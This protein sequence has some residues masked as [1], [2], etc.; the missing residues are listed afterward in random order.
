MESN[1]ITNAQGN[2]DFLELIRCKICLLISLNPVICKKCESVFCKLCIDNWAKQ[3]NSCPLRCKP[4]EIQ[5]DSRIIRNILSKFTYRCDICLNNIRLSDHEEHQTQCNQDLL[6]CELCGDIMMQYFMNT[7]LKLFCPNVAQTCGTCGAS[8]KRKDVKESVQVDRLAQLENELRLK[9]S[10]I[11]NLQMKIPKQGNIMCKQLVSSDINDV[12]VSDSSINQYRIKLNFTKEKE[13][14]RLNLNDITGHKKK[15]IMVNYLTFFKLNGFNYLIIAC[16]TGDIII[17]N[18]A[19]NKVLAT[20]NLHS[21]NFTQL[22]K[23]S[24]G[25]KE[26]LITSSFDR[27]IC[28]T[29]L[30][31]LETVK[32]NLDI[33][34]TCFLVGVS[35]DLMYYGDLK[36]N[37]KLILL[38]DFQ[39]VLFKN[40]HKSRIVNIEYTDN[41][42]NLITYAKDKYFCLLNPSN[43]NIVKAINI[44][45]LITSS[46][47]LDNLIFFTTDIGEIYKFDK[48]DMN[49]LIKKYR[50][51]YNV[52]KGQFEING[53]KLGDKTYLTNSL[54]GKGVEFYFYEGDKVNT[55]HTMKIE[56]LINF[57][58]IESSY[59]VISNNDNSYNNTVGIYSKKGINS[60]FTSFNAFYINI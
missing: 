17:H 22:K 43:L 2:E 7:H 16:S 24:I 3:K 44:D 45:Y 35:N 31:N 47:R 49:L 34:A 4:L 39:V 19:E 53:Y 29:G 38:S 41:R 5:A 20:K 28:I 9:D 11:H 60:E 30:D 27:T 48:D 25:D 15:L 8:V 57:D 21:D 36:G 23:L 40:I 50:P 37:I 18:L 32:H 58:I 10:I 54:A 46:I 13:L 12:S 26:Y 14:A 55:I 1:Q 51:N 59:D 56:N 42:D 33:P 6:T 52:E